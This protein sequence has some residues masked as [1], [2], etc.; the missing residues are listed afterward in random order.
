MY[1][2]YVLT[3]GL[4]D[5]LKGAGSVGIRPHDLLFDEQISE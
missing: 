3:R 4:V 1:P 2:R 5:L